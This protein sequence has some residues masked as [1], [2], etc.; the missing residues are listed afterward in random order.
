MNFSL[1]IITLNVSNTSNNVILVHVFI[2]RKCLQKFF[3]GRGGIIDHGMESYKNSNLIFFRYILF[4][5]SI[6]IKHI[7]IWPHFYKSWTIYQLILQYLWTFFKCYERLSY[8]SFHWIFLLLYLELILPL[9]L[10]F[11]FM[12]K[13]LDTSAI[14][15]T[16]EPL[17]V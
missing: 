6:S 3:Y 4:C 9:A 10:I 1:T 8:I 2:S 16:I 7:Y 13:C 11:P 12:F 14:F 15:L 17:Q 5:T